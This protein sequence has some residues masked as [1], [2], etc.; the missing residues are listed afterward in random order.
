[1]FGWC[2]PGSDLWCALSLERL[3][4]CPTPW[5]SESVTCS[6]AERWTPGPFFASCNG[7]RKGETRLVMMGKWLGRKAGFT[8]RRVWNRTW[9]F[10]RLQFW[11]RK[12][13]DALDWE[14][15]LVRRWQCWELLKQR[16]FLSWSTD[17]RFLG[18]RFCDPGSPAVWLRLQANLRSESQRLQSARSVPFDSECA[19]G[20]RAHTTLLRSKRKQLV[21]RVCSSVRD[22]P[23][24]HCRWKRLSY[25]CTWF[26]SSASSG[27][28]QFPRWKLLE[29]SVL[30]AAQ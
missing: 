16:G 26:G 30:D 28:A 4:G 2:I 17:L 15:N 3:P 5:F 18:F 7:L 11:S 12:S 23:P 21:Y 27:S 6:L 29:Y 24:P 19:L 9:R 13:P 22:F 14:G 20:F 25:C 8:C 1:M 10:V